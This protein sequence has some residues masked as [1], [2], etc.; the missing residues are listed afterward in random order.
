MANTYKILGQSLPSDTTATDLYTVPNSTAAVVS[1]ITATNVNATASAIS[2]YVVS[3]GNSAG[4]SNALVYQ[5]ELS[6]NSVQGFT[7][8]ITLGAGDKLV[9]QSA[10]ASSTTYQAFGSEVN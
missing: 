9:V 5:A 10:T 3:A 2:I 7:L 1:T 8:G 4:T 6:A